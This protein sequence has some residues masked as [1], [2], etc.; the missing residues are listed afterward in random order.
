MQRIVMALMC[1]AAVPACADSPVGMDADLQPSFAA[2]ATTT[3]EKIP[4]AL[5]VFVSCAAGGAGEDV[6][7][8]GTLHIMTHLTIDATGGINARSHFQPQRIS[9]TGLT[10]GD[11]YQ[12]TG[13]TQ[14]R[15][16]VRAAGFPVQFTFINNFRI[17]GQ[18]RGNNF[19]V[20][21]NVHVTINAN[22][23]VT[24]DVVNATVD[25]K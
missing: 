23:V 6:L 5:L 20:H 25:C 11:M 15:L 4:F 7:L 19:L 9:G 1:A 18:G 10:T 16:G 12:A 13:V 3:N 8:T 24:A 21:E 22:G 17:I 2:V 14:D